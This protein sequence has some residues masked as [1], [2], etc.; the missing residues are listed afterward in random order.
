M[1]HGGNAD[2]SWAA[3]ARE[4]VSMPVIVNGD[5][6]SAEDAERALRVTRCSGVMVGRRAIEHPWVFREARALLDHGLTLAEPTADERLDLCREHLAAN[7]AAR[8]ERR[9]VC[10][11]R[12]HLGGYLRG[13][14]GA[15]ALRRELFSCESL[16]GSL[17]ILD[18]Y[19]GRSA[20]A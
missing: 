6:K 4:V 19:Q 2:W 16:T 18:R 13:L 15:A 17:D 8:G 5:V 14:P 11:T 12:R 1:G 3:K 10:C 9:G 20:A 7:A